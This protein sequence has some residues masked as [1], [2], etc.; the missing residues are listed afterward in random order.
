[1]P[2]CAKSEM[3]EMSVVSLLILCRPKSQLHAESAYVVATYVST[4]NYHNY[5]HVYLCIVV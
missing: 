3:S 1:M 2:S 5:G 4:L